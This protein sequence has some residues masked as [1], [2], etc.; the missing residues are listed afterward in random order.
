MRKPKYPKI[1]LS[2]QEREYLKKH[3]LAAVVSSF[4]SAIG[5]KD[6]D[7]LIRF[8]NG[9]I[10]TYFSVDDLYDNFLKARSKG[11]Y[12]WKH[13]RRPGI[14]FIKGGVM[15][16]PSDLKVKDSELM[17]DLQD[18]LMENLFKDL[19]KNEVTKAVLL[20]PLTGS[21]MAKYYIGGHVIQQKVL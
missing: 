16:L 4:I 6:G 9:S 12:F 13:I 11:K 3:D 8:R 21:K 1:R 10:Y 7:L 5:V 2:K 17:N 20:D 19:I 18:E 14:P 15:P